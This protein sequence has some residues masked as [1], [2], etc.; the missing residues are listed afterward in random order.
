M[1]RMLRLYRNPLPG[2]LYLISTTHHN[3]H[4]RFVNI[5]EKIQSVTKFR[6]LKQRYYSI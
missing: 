2:V 6:G 5:P 3:K 1:S 4:K